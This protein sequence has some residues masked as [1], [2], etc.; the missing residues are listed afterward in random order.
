MLFFFFKQ[1]TAYDMRISDWSSD[2]CSSDLSNFA[3]ILED[4]SRNEEVLVLDSPVLTC[5]D[6]ARLKASFGD[7][8]AEIDCT[9]P[10]SGGPEQLP[11]AITRIREAAETAVRGRHTELFLPDENVDEEQGGIDITVAAAAVL[12]HLLRLGVRGYTATTHASPHGPA[13]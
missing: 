3:N 9:Y 7:A 6:W 8:V 11:A 1:K 4:R 12:P 10:S 2:V 5:A 13:N